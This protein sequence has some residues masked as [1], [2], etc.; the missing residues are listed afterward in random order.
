MSVWGL[1]LNRVSFRAQSFFKLGH[2][3]LKLG[4]VSS[5][6]GQFRDWPVLRLVQLEYILSAFNKMSNLLEFLRICT[7]SL[8]DNVTRSFIDCHLVTSGFWI[9]WSVWIGINTLLAFWMCLANSID[10]IKR[11]AT[12][13]QRVRFEILGDTIATI[14]MKMM[15]EIWHISR[16]KLSCYHISSHTVRS[17]Q[18][19]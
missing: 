16:C 19:K 17:E 15:V 6:C 3:Y 10:I 1:F 18:N 8:A 12:I 5:G 14:I 2:F 11:T 9:N 7:L 13:F 4:L